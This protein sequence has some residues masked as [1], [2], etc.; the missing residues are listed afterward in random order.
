MQ[1]RFAERRVNTNVKKSTVSMALANHETQFDVG[2]D[3][4]FSETSLPKIPN[5]YEKQNKAP[6]KQNSGTED[7]RSPRHLAC[8]FAFV[9]CRQDLRGVRACP[10]VCSCLGYVSLHLSSVVPWLS[11][12]ERRGLSKLTIYKFVRW[13]MGWGRMKSLSCPNSPLLFFV[14][15]VLFT[16]F[17]GS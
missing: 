12:N 5:L 13:A 2:V 16:S 1:R 9:F 15:M 6:C 8:S 14:T 10:F 7:C 11:H 3:A 4:A 17:Q